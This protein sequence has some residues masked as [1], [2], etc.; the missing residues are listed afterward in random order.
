M[1]NA[2]QIKSLDRYYNIAKVLL[3]VTPFLCL[4]YLS[5]G[6]A[7]TGASIPQIIQEDPRNMVMFLISMIN[8]LISYL[9]TFMHKKVHD[10]DIAYSVVN[11]VVLIVAEIML[12]NA[13]YVILLGFLLVKT[14][15]THNVSFKE[16]L[17]EKWNKSFFVTI[18]GSI[19]VLVLTSI[20]LF[21]TLR[22]DM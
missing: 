21:A 5:M 10:G 14:L 18:S 1:T 3:I 12:Q 15:K 22:I 2:K 20:C 6:A 9:L 19:L 8:P 13:W 17:N 11:L 4:M 7:K 16:C